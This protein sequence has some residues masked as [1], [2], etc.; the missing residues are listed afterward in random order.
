MAE[1]VLSSLSKH[2]DP[3]LDGQHMRKAG[4][5][6]CTCDPS[7]GRRQQGTRVISQVSDRF[8]HKEQGVESGWSRTREHEHLV[9]TQHIHVYAYTQR[10]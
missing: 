4:I 5:A 1:W 10:I 7:A 3:K 9:C 2:K 8:H 6:E